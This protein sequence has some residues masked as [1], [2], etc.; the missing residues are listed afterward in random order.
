[1]SVWLRLGRDHVRLELLDRWGRPPVVSPH[2]TALR[3]VVREAA[4]IP[5]GDAASTAA[6]AAIPPPEFS[7]A[8]SVCLVIP[9]ETRRGPWQLYRGAAIRWTEQSTP[10]AV[11]RTLL[12]A[13]GVHRPVV[14]PDLRDLEGWTVAANGAGGFDDHRQAGRTRAGTVVRLHPAWIEADARIVLADVSFHYFAGFG[15]GRKLVFPGLGDPAG[16]LGNHRLCLDAEG[17]L[18][19]ECEPGQLD[20]NPVHEDLMEAVALAP[21]H[22]LLQ[23]HEPAPGEAAVL[24]AGDWRETHAS[25]CALFHRGHMLKHTQRPDVLIAD[26]GGYPRD[27]SV[28]QAHKSLQHAMRFLDPGGRLLLVAGL[29]EGSGSE[30]LE[31]LWGLDPEDLSRRAV[32]A[33]ELH[34]HTALAMKTACR[35]VEVAVWSRLENP[36]RLRAIPITPLRDEAEALQWLESKGTPRQWGWL[37]RAEEVLPQIVGRRERGDEEANG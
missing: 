24:T 14:S 33:Y 27:A 23:A 7:T 25:G 22:L 16:I 21:P 8:R 37:T 30:T 6:I 11:R 26:A 29:E 3:A 2:R 15:G 12:I 32:E 36:E 35:R 9:D 10:R 34:T 18:R 1:V 4:G 13:T 19:P 28:L 31:R 17:R 20:G 5:A